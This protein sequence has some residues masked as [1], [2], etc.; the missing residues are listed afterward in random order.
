[1]TAPTFEHRAS[2]RS[3]RAVFS[4]GGARRSP[5]LT[6]AGDRARRHRASRRRTAVQMLLTV[7]IALVLLAVAP[8][9][10]AT[11]TA[12]P[13]TAAPATAAPGFSAVAGGEVAHVDFV[14]Q[15]GL[16]VERLVDP[17][18]SIA[19]ST[20][21]SLGTSMAY[22]STPYPGETVIGAPPLLAGF[23]P[24]A[25]P[26]YPFYTSST[27]P[28]TPHG[29][30]SAGN[31]SLDATSAVA[32]SQSTATDG[33]NRTRSSVSTDDKSGEVVAEAESHVGEIDLGA[34]FNLSDL[35]SS[36]KVVRDASGN[37]QR[38]SD[39]S[40][41]RLNVLGQTFGITPDG[42][43]LGGQQVPVGVKPDELFRSLLDQ[44][45]SRG[46]AVKILEPVKTDTG[47]TSGA[48]QVT[49]DGSVPSYG[50]GRITYTFGRTTASIAP[51]GGGD[52][53]LT[54]DLGGIV[55]ASGS[56]LGA[57]GAVG[58]AGLSPVTANQPTATP[59]PLANSPS[60]SRVRSPQAVTTGRALDQT[61]SVFR[62]YP[63]LVV[64]AAGLVLV[65]SLF[66]HFGV[67]L[68][69]TS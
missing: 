13:A 44:L 27:Y 25:P 53:G 24:V 9:R 39:L 40:I 62:F 45:A 67:R 3:I 21:D 26:D 49:Y 32:S 34:R 47:M 30:A 51:S 41:G 29:H 31:V 54:E 55:G 61:S 18:S 38:K 1:M 22:A 19:Q 14:L 60:P 36:V 16:L 48:L 5:G 33:L 58:G 52:E 69:W 7:L 12:A 50:K 65:A 17:G 11:A 35:R 20:L 46:V 15:P 59:E 4:A 64:V 43:E 63:V 10:A 56:D 66:R 68:A 2:E 37:L 23:L 42:I 6:M 57:V 28:T 8:G